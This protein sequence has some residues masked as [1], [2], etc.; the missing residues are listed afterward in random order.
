MKIRIALLTLLIIIATGC[1]VNFDDTKKEA[2]ISITASAGNITYTQA[3]E[4]LTDF[5]YSMTLKNNIEV[6]LDGVTVKYLKVN[7][8]S[9]AIEAEIPE[10]VNPI[11]DM[12]S[13]YLSNKDDKQD[14]RVEY[15]PQ[16][17]RT[18][19][20][21]ENV[22]NIYAVVTFNFTQSEDDSSIEKVMPP[23]EIIRK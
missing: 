2:K 6:Y 13:I 10:L 15:V 4:T 8:T 12:S 7:T 18:Y 9:G 17:V 5:Y 1:V 14:V 23:V 22:K 16:N 20:N 19:M 21:T 11:S 3:T